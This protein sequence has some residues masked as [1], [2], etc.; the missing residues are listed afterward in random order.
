MPPSVGNV[1]YFELGNEYDLSSYD[2]DRSSPE[3]LGPSVSLSGVN[4]AGGTLAA[5]ST[6]SYEV[7]SANTQGSLSVPGSLASITLPAGDNAVALSWSAT[8]VDDLSPSGY[9][10]Y[11]RGSGGQQALVGVGGDAAGGLSWTDKGTITPSGSPNSSGQSWGGTIFTPNVYVKMWNAIAPAMKAVDSSVGI[12]GP[13]LSNAHS[14]AGTPWLDTTCVTSA[15]PAS[16][17]GCVNGDSG[18][19]NYTDYIPYLLAH[20]N[21]Q[22]A[23]ITFHAYG[24]L[25]NTEP[26]TFQGTQSELSSYDS[27]D[28]AAID[29]AGVPVWIDETNLN[30]DNAGAQSSATD[31]RAMTQLGSAWLADELVQWANTDP[32][33]RQLV[34]Y[35]ADGANDA[36]FALFG[37]ATKAGDT[38]CIP[39]PACQSI[40][41]G[42][43]D[44][45][46][47][48]IKSINQWLTNGKIVPVTNVPAGYVALAVQTSPTNIVMI[49]VNEQT[50]SANG[51][52]AP[53]TVNVQ[54]QGATVTD[55]KQIT[56]NGS[57]NMNAGP[58]TQD[59]GAQSHLN[60]N[61]AGYEVDLLNYT[62]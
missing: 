38:S 6:Y 55:T 48:T 22:P 17:G 9:V 50:G 28:K 61:T 21:T 30:A 27:T 5:G 58:T 1:Q 19:M 18:W 11:G 43:P 37:T 45:E 4:V 20:A 62:L 8:S 23:A 51:N 24:G 31:F 36:N 44:L 25:N 7:A 3:M 40:T 53:G 49:L 47:W 41:L 46:Y 2:Q 59:L 16:G 29:A 15:P 14:V 39:Q 42:E 56:I 13:T 10:I 52:G 12:T 54:L 35:E 34:Q 32:Q 33:I 26:G 60:L 57:T